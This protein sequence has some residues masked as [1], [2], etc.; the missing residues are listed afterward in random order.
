LVVT[1]TYTE[2]ETPAGLLGDVNCDGKVD[3]GDI[4]ALSAYLLGKG[5]LTAQGLANADASLNGAVDSSDL[6]AIFALI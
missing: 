1:A 4:S 2:N 5:E 6:S 3:M